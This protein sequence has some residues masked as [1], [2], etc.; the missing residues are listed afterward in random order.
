MNIEVSKD[1]ELAVPRDEDLQNRGKLFKELSSKRRGTR[2]VDREE[3]DR[4]TRSG[5]A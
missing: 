1:N 4:A 3:G 2:S 5:N